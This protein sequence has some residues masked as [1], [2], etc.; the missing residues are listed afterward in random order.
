ML[1]KILDYARHEEPAMVGAAL[2]AVG[3]VLVEQPNW[4]QA[5]IVGVGFILRHFVSPAQ[6]KQ[7][8]AVETVIE[9]SLPDDPRIVALEEAVKGITARIGG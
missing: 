3:D 2:V 8:A 4:R 1:K 9:P 6:A 7:I 5:A